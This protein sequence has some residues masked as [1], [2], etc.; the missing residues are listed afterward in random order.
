MGYGASLE[1]IQIYLIA[2]LLKY[3]SL[4]EP[5]EQECGSTKNP[6]PLAGYRSSST[7]LHLSKNMERKKE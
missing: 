6:T 4:C 3:K 5:H 1:I 2:G 7:S